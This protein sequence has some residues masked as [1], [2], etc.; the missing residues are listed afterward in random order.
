MRTERSELLKEFENKFNEFKKEMKFKASLEELDSIFNVK[1]GVLN[2]GYVSEQLGRQISW[3]IVETLNGWAN[4]LHNLV[5]PMPHNMVSNTESQLFNDSEK[6][7]LM[8]LMNTIMAHNS[9]N[10]LIGLKKDMKMQAEFIDN[11][12]NL[13]KET[14]QPKLISTI[15]KVNN[16]WKS[17]A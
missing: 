16:Y 11:S 10:S 12:V 1:D 7:D 2:T 9:T 8:Q 13:W 4:Y 15:E 6:E 14:V 3:R 5:M 17:K